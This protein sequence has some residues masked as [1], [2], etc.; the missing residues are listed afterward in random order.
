MLAGKTSLDYSN[1]FSPNDYKKND[2]I[3]YK[4]LEIIMVEEASLEFKLRKIDETR[5]Y[6]LDKKIND[7]MCEKYK[8]TCEYLNYVGHLIILV[9]TVY[10]LCFNFY[11]YFITLFSCWHYKFCSR[12]KNLCSHCKN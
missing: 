6:L 8:K 10:L 2:K 9:S 7:L 11:I 4:Y 1:L 3:I 12:N 5:N